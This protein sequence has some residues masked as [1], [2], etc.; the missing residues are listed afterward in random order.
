MART[1]KIISWNKQKIVFFGALAK[2]C[3]IRFQR[4]RKNIKCTLRLDA[5]KTKVRQA[6]IEKIA[7][8][9]I[10][11]N[12]GSLI[13]ADSSDALKQAWRVDIAEGTSGS[14]HGSVGSLCIFQLT[15]NNNIANTLAGKR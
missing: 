3:G 1:A 12:I 8:A 10:D 5:G 15:W 2:C 14:A 11:G 13:C 6:V 9:L 4:A 7:V